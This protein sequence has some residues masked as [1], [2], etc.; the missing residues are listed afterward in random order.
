MKDTPALPA[1][2]RALGERLNHCAAKIGGK[3]AL[4]AAAGI[5]EAQL[6]RYI[7]GESEMGASK[8]LALAE[9][10]GVSV[11][12]LLT[13]AG[14]RESRA[15]QGYVQPP[16]DPELMEALVKVLDELLIEYQT[17][18]SPR[19]RAQA[20]ALIYEGLRY[21]FTN[22]GRHA[23]VDRAVLLEILEYFDHF[24]SPDSIN[25]FK[26]F[27][28]LSPVE[29][30]SD[31]AERFAAATTRGAQNLYEHFNGKAYFDRI[32]SS[33]YPSTTHFLNRLIECAQDSFG[34][35]DTEF[36][37]LGAGN[38]RDL[39]FLRNTFPH[40]NVKGLEISQRGLRLAQKSIASGRLPL[41][42]IVAGDIQELPYTNK[43]Q[44][45]VYSR[46]TLF[47]LLYAPR[48]NVGI[49]AVFSEVSRILDTKGIFGIITHYGR[50]RTFMPFCQLLDENDIQQLAERH[51][52]E[53]VS[54]GFHYPL[55]GVHD[56]VA[57]PLASGMGSPN[58][59]EAILR[60]L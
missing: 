56:A 6:F 60:K 42:S 27:W 49:E 30:S 35:T 3:R 29:I 36:L 19:Q 51:G 25:V 57:K 20:T 18:L 37:D 16:F 13:G 21:D 33:P 28:K 22:H 9:A 38:G 32:S 50:G 12:W 7:N 48:H 40:L 45:I 47:H 24:K 8:L 39:V 31:I 1:S 17:R 52:F 14:E 46:M 2:A 34:L 59:L 54:S 26:S 5:S 23:P 53:V 41:D 15:H 10:A 55:E 4:A 11:Q 58:Y 43:T 44:Q